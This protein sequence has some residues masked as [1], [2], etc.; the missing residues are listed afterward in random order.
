MTKT[1]LRVWQ[2]CQK[3]R[4]LA[5][6]EYIVAGI[7]GGADSVCLLLVL[8]ELQ[9]LCPFRLHAVHV[10]HGIRAEAEA[11]EAWVKALCEKRGVPFTSFHEDVRGFA[12]ENGLS[13]EEAGR[14]L[15]YRA[16]EQV[17]DAQMAAGPSGVMAG[18][19]AV[20]HNANDRAETLLF[21]LF[22]G[23]GLAGMGSIRPCRD[24]VIRPL[25]G[26]SRA[27]IE[28]YLREMGQDW[29]IDA[30]NAEDT[31][32]R[33]R[34]RHHILPYAESK[35][36]GGAVAHLAAEAEHLAGA[37][38]FIQKQVYQ[39]LD[40]CMAGKG[41]EDDPNGRRAEVR[42]L[43]L[44][45]QNEDPF[46]Q[47]EMLMQC[48]RDL[49]RGRDMTR[50][51]VAAIRYLFSPD[52]QSGRKVQAAGLRAWKEFDTV[53]LQRERTE[54]DTQEPGGAKE[55]AVKAG[56]I[57]GETLPVTVLHGEAL[58]PEPGETAVFVVPGL[59]RVES[60]VRDT[61]EMADFLQNIPRNE[62]TKWFD[63]DKII[64]SV[65]FR[66][67]RTGDYLTI[68][69]K[70]QK[71]KLQDYFIEQKIPAGQREELVVLAEGA[72]ILWVPGYRIS[73]AYK[74]TE[75]TRRIWEVHIGGEERW[76]KE[77]E[78]C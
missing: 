1:A 60:R 47:D 63:Y 43:V 41:T 61:A 21:H 51:D 33:N 35:I 69:E 27:E 73:A 14:V 67:R 2:Y 75:K 54:G 26:I 18:K 7:S 3:Y 68:N 52:C 4:L 19:I 56:A 55:A 59:G 11:D 9:K 44:A 78:Y 15:R 71:K 32:T 40:R 62:Y 65:R 64:E 24:R 12:K 48:I 72:R 45:M 5:D 39:A 29:R 22:R 58:E 49:G 50:K 30:T 46:L 23:T 36:C 25:L 17:L 34:I 6:T 53:V 66:T 57:P 70:L 8:Q 42:L 74:V 13:E 77:S 20:A 31:Y 76:Q 16:M 10:N 38:E 37:A 28:A